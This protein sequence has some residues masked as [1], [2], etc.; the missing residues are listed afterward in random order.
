M[1]ETRAHTS[2]KF[3]ALVS[4]FGSAP[5]VACEVCDEPP[6]PVQ[7]TPVAIAPVAAPPPAPEVA[8]V[9]AATGADEEAAPPTKRPRPAGEQ[10]T[11]S[12]IKAFFA[13]KA[14]A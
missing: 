11:Q 3:V 5:T 2:E 1:L 13:R 4:L 8:P 7:G 6:P 14:P 9:E 12:S 10:L